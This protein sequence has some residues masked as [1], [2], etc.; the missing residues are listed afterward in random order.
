MRSVVVLIGIAAAF[1]TAS[2]RV[3]SK[4]AEA[5]RPVAVPPQ[6]LPVLLASNSKSGEV[7]VRRGLQLEFGPTTVLLITAQHSPGTVGTAPAATARV[8]H[9][10]RRLC[11]RPRPRHRRSR[12][13]RR[14]RPPP[15][16]QHF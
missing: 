12:S 6:W 9:R 1:C 14:R 16:P 15:H 3:A 10:R 13:R 4:L 7:E 5:N 2:T 8:T 11:P